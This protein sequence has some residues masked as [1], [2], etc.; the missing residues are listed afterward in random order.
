MSSYE[1]M[2]IAVGLIVPDNPDGSPN[3]PGVDPFTA[4]VDNSARCDSGGLEAATPTLCV[5]GYQ[6]THGHYKENANASGP[7]GETTL[8]GADGNPTTDVA[9]ADFY[10]LPGDLSLR[11]QLGI[12]TVKLGSD[13]RFTNLDGGLIPHT[14]TTCAYPCLG[15]TGAAFPLPNGTTSDGRPIELDSSELGIGIPAISGVK[16]E[17]TWTVPVTEQEG[18]RPDEVV[19]YFCRIHPSMRGAFKVVP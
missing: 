2:G 8:S 7:S 19:T 11:D 4:P 10:Y 18:Y 9:I 15:D 5:N 16:N 3:A 13:L 6:E 17:L 14:I 12:P 1:D